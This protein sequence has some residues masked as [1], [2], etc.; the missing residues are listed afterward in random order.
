MTPAI[1]LSCEPTPLMWTTAST[2]SADA[3]TADSVTITA[4]DSTH[5]A[6]EN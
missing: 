1:N 6:D 5:T 2:P 3:F 4:D